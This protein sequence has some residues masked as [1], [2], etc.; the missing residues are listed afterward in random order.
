[1]TLPEPKVNFMPTVIPAA[2][3]TYIVEIGSRGA[4]LR[5]PVVAW[6]PD[7]DNPYR[8]PHPMTVDGLARL[9]RGRAILHPCGMVHSRDFTICFESV[10]EWASVAEK[11][12]EKAA[13]EAPKPTPAQARDAEQMAS[14]L[15]I[16]WAN[17]PY[18]TNSFYRYTD[19]DLDFVFQV[20]GG[21]NPPKQKDPVTK[22][23]RDEFTSLRKT[24]D[25]AEYE[26]LLEGRAPGLDD[27]G[28]FED[29]E[30]DDDDLLGAGPSDEDDDDD[31]I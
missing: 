17:S 23:K 1:M 26:D 31:L 13:P 15:R 21:M 24:V 8:A 22:I 18:K 6:A 9:T 11:E 12:P 28:S 20:D 3:G 10:E 5:T 30:D 4:V 16:E 7:A 2:A 29:D 27:I 19:G 25:V 14:E